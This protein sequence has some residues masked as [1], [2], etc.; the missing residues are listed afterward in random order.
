MG[1][2]M[3]SWYH[4]GIACTIL[5]QKGL[6][7]QLNRSALKYKRLNLPKSSNEQP[8]ITAVTTMVSVLLSVVAVRKNF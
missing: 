2:T 7:V 1:G 5:K 3:G 8:N 6:P 4:R